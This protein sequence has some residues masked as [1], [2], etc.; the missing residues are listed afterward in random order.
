MDVRLKVTEKI[1][2]SINKALENILW[3]QWMA[4][5]KLYKFPIAYYALFWFF[6]WSMMT[7]QYRVN[8]FDIPIDICQTNKLKISVSASTNVL[9]N[10]SW[11]LYSLCVNR[12]NVP[13]QCHISS[14][15]FPNIFSHQIVKLKSTEVCFF[16]F[17]KKSDFVFIKLIG[18]NR[19]R[20]LIQKI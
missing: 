15:S 11:T 13:T 18:H 1:T 10:K 2:V 3:V 6:S 7:R 14:L 8:V 4:S 12:Y 20:N 17:L 19:R 5:R 16:L 9:D